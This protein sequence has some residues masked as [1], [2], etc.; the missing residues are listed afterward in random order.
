MTLCVYGP[1][2]C[3]TLMM[4]VCMLC[5]NSLSIGV[6]PRVRL[7]VYPYTGSSLVSVWGR[8]EEP[9]SCVCACAITRSFSGLPLHTHQEPEPSSPIPPQPRAVVAIKSPFL[10]TTTSHRLRKIL[11]NLPCVPG[12]LRL[13]TRVFLCTR[14]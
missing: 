2:R 7:A 5:F 12:F 9:C 6:N 3:Q 10:I 14:P 11:A 8:F 4:C 1:S 13:N